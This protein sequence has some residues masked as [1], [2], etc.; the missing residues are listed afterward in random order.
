MRLDVGMFHPP[1]WLQHP[2]SWMLARILPKHIFRA[3]FF[4]NIQVNIQANILRP[5]HHLHHVY[6]FA[7]LLNYNSAALFSL[8]STN[9]F[10]IQPA[11]SH[12]HPHMS[13]AHVHALQHPSSPDQF[14]HP[15]VVTSG[16]R[17][18]IN[19]PCQRLASLTLERHPFNIQRHF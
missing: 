12:K 17:H 16:P 18:P 19:I 14:Q 15:C 7:H 4:F 9:T 5:S 1:F 3:L 2:E 8:T 11:P 13:F 6:H 10:N